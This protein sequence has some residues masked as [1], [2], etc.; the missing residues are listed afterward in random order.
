MFLPEEIFSRA[1]AELDKVAKELGLSGEVV[2]D[3]RAEL[4]KQLHADPFLQSVTVAP[5]NESQDY[6]ARLRAWREKIGD[7]PEIAKPL[8]EKANGR[9]DELSVEDI[10]FLAALEIDVLT[11]APPDR[12]EWKPR[13]AEI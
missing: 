1:N 11:E 8:Q 12:R 6:G 7:A 13:V 4:L 2:E 3:A 10:R 9:F 5:K